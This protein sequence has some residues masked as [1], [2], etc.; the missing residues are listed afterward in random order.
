MSQVS[1][2]ANSVWSFAKCSIS[3]FHDFLK[4]EIS[5]SFMEFNVFYTLFNIQ[6]I[7]MSLSLHFLTSDQEL[8]A[9][10]VQTFEYISAIKEK[11]QSAMKFICTRCWLRIYCLA[12]VESKD[13][14]K[15]EWHQ[16]AAWWW[17]AV[18]WSRAEFSRSRRLQ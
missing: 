14:Q 2:F 7:C 9:S 10:T 15:F 1:S 3:C 8:I 17:S 5:I 12:T 13:Y 16:N 6:Y 11:I 4:W 18:R